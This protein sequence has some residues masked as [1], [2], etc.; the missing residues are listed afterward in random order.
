MGRVSHVSERK[1]N[2]LNPRHHPAV[3]PLHACVRHPPSGA[4]DSLT[5]DGFEKRGL[6]GTGRVVK[7][8]QYRMVSFASS[9]G[10]HLHMRYIAL[11]RRQR[12]SFRPQ[13]FDMNVTASSIKRS[14]CSRSSPTAMQPGR[15]GTNA[16]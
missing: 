8:S 10:I 15:S 2:P 14:V 5:L 9:R 6:A 1:T 3:D 12:Q 4:S 16:P 7:T 11:R 13:P